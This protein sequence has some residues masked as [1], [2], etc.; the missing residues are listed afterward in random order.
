MN[1]IKS[2]ILTFI[3]ILSGLILK[4]QTPGQN[5]DKYWN[6]KE[7]LTTKFMVV[8][9]PLSVHPLHIDGINL[10]ANWRNPTNNFDNHNQ[11]KWADAE[12]HL[13]SKKI[14][15]GLQSILRNFID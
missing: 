9:N 13:A 5:L 10:P 2:I 4:G 6:Y 12:H 1:N 7:R 8:E 11:I 14:P 3:F 15:S